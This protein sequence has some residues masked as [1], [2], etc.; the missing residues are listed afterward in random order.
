MTALRQKEN[1]R[2]LLKLGVVPSIVYFAVFVLFTYPLITLFSSHFFADRGDGLQ[3]VWNLWWVDAA[4]TKLGQNPWTTRYLHYPYGIS[5]LGHTLNTTNGLMSIPLVRI[6]S[7]IQAHNTLIV[8]SFVGSGF[9]AFCLAYYLTRAY[10]P[11]IIAGFVYSFSNYHFA[12]AQ[13][14]MQLVAL[15]WIPLFVLLWYVLLTRPSLWV[16]LGA[17]L[18]LLLVIL[19]DYYYFMYTALAAAFMAV[20][21][22]LWQRDALFF[23]RQRYR[24]P[25]LVF[26][27]GSLFTSGVLV[28]AVLRQQSTDP[29]LAIYVPERFSLDLLAPFIPGGHWRFAE[30]TKSYWSELPGNIH[31]S[32]VYLGLSVVFVVIYVIIRWR[33]ADLPSLPYWYFVLVFFFIMGLGPVLQVN[34]QPV[35]D[36][37]LPYDLVFQ[38][39]FPPLRVARVPVR[40]IVIVIL[41]ASV[42]SAVGFKLL[43]QQS[44]RTRVLAWLLIG[45]LV[46]EYLPAPIPAS[47]VPVPPYI[48]LLRDLPGKEGVLDAANRTTIAMYYQTLYEK[49]MAF[50]YVSRM[51]ASTEAKDQ[52]LH[53]VI[54]AGRYDELCQRYGIRYVLAKPDRV[55]SSSD[56]SLRVL[57]DQDGVRLFDLGAGHGCQVAPDVVAR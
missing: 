43:F 3:N 22:A 40:M 46:V 51:P 33:K 9:M 20:W 55:V 34:G 17:V 5:L 44:K 8:F 39:L 28:A 35:S 2:A 14:H 54:D 12:H 48:A 29:L 13:G 56:P 1:L 16:S 26:L 42:I 19:N 4:L 23:V 27:L 45:I 21:V 38:R 32:S 47:Q 41:S 52:A 37:M 25:M 18:A 49:P 36:F 10:W 15:Q 57:Y 24:L 30:L 11:S 6:L 31:E 7:P 50:G 53:A